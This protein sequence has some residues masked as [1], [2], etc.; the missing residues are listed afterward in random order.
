MYQDD[1]FTSVEAIIP[2]RIIYYSQGCVNIMRCFNKM[3][4]GQGQ[5]QHHTKKHTLGHNFLIDYRTSDRHQ[6]VSNWS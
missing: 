2:I 6:N 3:S 5:G 1:P 4:A